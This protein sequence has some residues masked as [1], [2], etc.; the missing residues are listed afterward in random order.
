MLTSSQAFWRP[1]QASVTRLKVRPLG[2]GSSPVGR[3]V[4]RSSSSIPIRRCWV[5]VFSMWTRPT[6]PN[7]KLPSA[8]TAICSGKARMCG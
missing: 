1:T 4:S 5:I 2:C 8:M 6:A 7:G 3:T